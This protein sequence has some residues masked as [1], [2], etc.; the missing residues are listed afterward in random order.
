M[1][2]RLELAVV[3]RVKQPFLV[4]D[5]LDLAPSLLNKLDRRRVFFADPLETLCC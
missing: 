1:R 3:E 2:C 4:S 5:P